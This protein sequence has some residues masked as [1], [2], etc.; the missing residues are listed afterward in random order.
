MH[1]DEE[2]AEDPGILFRVLGSLLEARG[3]LFLTASRGA[4]HQAFVEGRAFL[5]GAGGRP[6]SGF[7]GVLLL[8]A[9]IAGSKGVADT[10][11]EAQEPVFLQFPK[12]ASAVGAGE[13][14]GPS[15]A[16]FTLDLRHFQLQ[17]PGFLLLERAGAL[18]GL[19]GFGEFFT[20]ETHD[21]RGNL[22]QRKDGG[23]RHLFPSVTGHGRKHGRQRILHDGDAA[24]SPDD[25]QP[26]GAVVEH[27]AEDDADDAGAGGN[28]GGAE[29]GVD[30]RA[31][32][33]LTGSLENPDVVALDEHVEVRRGDIDVAA[34]Q[35][36]PVFRM[37]GFQGG[38]ASKYLGQHAAAAPCGV[39]DDQHGGGDIRGQAGE[40]VLQRLDTACGGADHDQITMHSGIFRVRVLG[41]LTAALR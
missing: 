24:V 41:C 35:A 14:G 12:H 16:L 13:G 23:L 5:K 33:V 10:A 27:A 6:E 39:Q 19:S 31:V 3:G 25:H 1:L 36:L 30:R 22:F 21:F 8:D 29:Q 4:I 7:D 2:L 9:E 34:P 11:A 38:S 17:K 40:E 28:G 26:G 37:A 20:D 18:R 32:Q 15:R